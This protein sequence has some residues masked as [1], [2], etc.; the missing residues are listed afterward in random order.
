MSYY[1]DMLQAIKLGEKKLIKQRSKQCR[2]D[3]FFYSIYWTGVTN[4]PDSGWLCCKPGQ[5]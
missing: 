2:P 5:I 1:A 3:N 4:L